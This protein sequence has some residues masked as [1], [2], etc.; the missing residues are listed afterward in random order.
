MENIDFWRAT[1]VIAFFSC[2]ICVPLVFLGKPFMGS[3]GIFCF[4]LFLIAVTIR[5]KAISNNLED[6]RCTYIGS[7]KKT[8]PHIPPTQY[9]NCPD[10]VIRSK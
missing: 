10:G 9:F 2:I 5:D 1:V 6:L 3:V 7:G 4:I 8:L